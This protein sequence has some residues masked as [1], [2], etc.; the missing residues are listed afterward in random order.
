MW[1]RLPCRT[2]EQRKLRAEAKAAYERKHPLDGDSGIF[3]FVIRDDGKEFAIAKS[4]REYALWGDDTPARLRRVQL[5]AYV[6]VEEE[7]V[8]RDGGRSEQP[9]S[10]SVIEESQQ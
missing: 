7:L 5:K 8:R 10:V 3:T 9:T 2:F 1:W 4:G 6:E